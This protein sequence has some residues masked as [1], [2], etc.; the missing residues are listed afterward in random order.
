M[1]IKLS[2]HREKILKTDRKPDGRRRGR[3][4]RRTKNDAKLEE[5]AD[6]N[7]IGTGPYKFLIL[8]IGDLSRAKHKKILY[9]DRCELAMPRPYFEEILQDYIKHHLPKNMIVRDTKGG[10]R[11]WHD[12]TKIVAFSGSP[13]YGNANPRLVTR[14][15]RAYAKQQGKTLEVLIGQTYIPTTNIDYD[16]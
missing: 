3:K 15:L 11:I 16:W 13:S 5:M 1:Y 12:H 2:I 4:L 7:L 8:D 14:M 9:A 10:G 6:V